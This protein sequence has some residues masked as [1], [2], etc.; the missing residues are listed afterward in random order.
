MITKAIQLASGAVQV[1]LANGK[2]YVVSDDAGGWV[3]DLLAAY[4][5]SGGTVAE[6]QA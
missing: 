4:V 2:I 6:E 3:S 1:T 5:V